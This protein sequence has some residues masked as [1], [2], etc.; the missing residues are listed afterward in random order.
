G[1]NFLC[2][3]NAKVV[4]LYPHDVEGWKGVS[5]A[6]QIR[7]FRDEG[8]LMAENMVPPAMLAM[9][10]PAVGNEAFALMRRYNQM[11]ASAVLV[12]DSVTGRVMPGPLGMPL[13]QYRISDYDFRR[14][15]DGIVHLASLHFAAGAD[16]VLIPFGKAHA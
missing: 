8:I 16:R 5:Q 7:G 12:E 1:R 6:Q 9:T 3:P 14:F 13:I 15:R 4:G 2:H 10:Q 11:V